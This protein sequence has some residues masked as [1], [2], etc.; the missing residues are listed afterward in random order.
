MNTATNMSLVLTST[1]QLNY[2]GKALMQVGDYGVGTVGK[3]YLDANDIPLESG[4]YAG[5]GGNT[6]S[7]NNFHSYSP[8]IHACRSGGPNGSGMTLQIQGNTTNLLAYRQRNDTSWSRWFEIY[9]TANTTKDRNGNLKVSGSSNALSDYPVGAPIPW[10]QSTAPTGYLI[11]NGQTFNK[12]TYP[13]LASAYPSGKLPDLR[14]EFIRGLD[15]GRG[16]DVNRTV[17]SSQRCATEHHKHI[18]GWGEA[19][20]VN[21]TFG[22]TVKS[23]YAGSGDSD[24]DNYLFYTNDGSEFQGSN[25][26]PTGIMANETRPRNIAFLYIVRAA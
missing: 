26:N 6:T 25:P 18:S 9:S 5:G 19:G 20:I 12:T 3:I 4:F 13:L 21:A 14:G 16:I 11:C 7:G 2:G 1:G 22:K 17:L 15:A 23:G 24:H 8:L 10:P